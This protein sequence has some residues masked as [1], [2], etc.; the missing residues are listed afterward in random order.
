M[1][2]QTAQAGT[3]RRRALPSL[4]LGVEE[5]AASSLPCT[6]TLNHSL[7]LG[8]RTGSVTGAWPG[9]PNHT[10]L[11]GRAAIQV[12]ILN[13]FTLSL[14]HRSRILPVSAIPEHSPTFTGGDP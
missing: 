5:V 6:G 13:F 12:R 2:R 14:C 11:T 1:K 8:F 7:V 4:R 9:R 3:P 10:P